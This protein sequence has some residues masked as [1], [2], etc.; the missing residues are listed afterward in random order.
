MRSHRVLPLLAFLLLVAAACTKSSASSNGGDTASSSEV[1]D[2]WPT[3]DL[4]TPDRALRSYWALQDYRP[5]VLERDAREWD[6]RHARYR[7]VSDSLDELILGGDALLT[8]QKNRG[9]SYEERYAREILTVVQET[10]TRARVAA[11][12]RNATPIDSGV[13]PSRDDLERRRK[14]EEVQYILEKDARGW[15]V[16]QAKQQFL[17]DWNN[18]FDPNSQY[19]PTHVRP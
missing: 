3:V 18:H 12:I 1:G 4:T 15:H 9:K 5:A 2:T 6:R 16:V 10:D 14:G 17:G 7:A 11:V 8:A 13:T 19:V